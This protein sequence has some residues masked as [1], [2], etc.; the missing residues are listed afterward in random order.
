M[1]TVSLCFTK[2]K[3]FDPKTAVSFEFRELNTPEMNHDYI[4]RLL[5]VLALRMS[6][7]T[8]TSWESLRANI[9]AHPERRVV[10]TKPDRPVFCSLS[11]RAQ[12]VLQPDE[13]AGKDAFGKWLQQAAA[14]IG[15]TQRPITRDLRRG[16]AFEATQLEISTPTG[17]TAAARQLLEHGRST[18]DRGVMVFA[19]GKPSPDT[20]KALPRNHRCATSIK[21][22]WQ[23]QL[24]E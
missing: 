24:H 19:S 12:F 21:E 3:K 17:G 18:F 5:L 8:E 23:L 9:K 1:A 22:R 6:A 10:W 11:Q 13:P 7:V 15:A 20:G 4:I 16:A 14:L 2:G